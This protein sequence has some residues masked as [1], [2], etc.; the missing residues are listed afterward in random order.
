MVLGRM[1]AREVLE[2]PARG[3]ALG[4]RSKRGRKKLVQAAAFL[5]RS[6]PMDTAPYRQTEI[7]EIEDDETAAPQYEDDR[8]EAPGG[9]GGEEDEFD[10][11][12]D[13]DSEDE[14]EYDPT[15]QLCQL[16][17]SEDGTPIADILLGIRDALER[18]NKIL[19]KAVTVLEARK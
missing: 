9:E 11:D 5:Y 16:M 7:V 2:V 15:E 8:A 17:M 4:P 10:D 18:H 1:R 14:E 19:Y 6:N 3:D 12:D 13:E